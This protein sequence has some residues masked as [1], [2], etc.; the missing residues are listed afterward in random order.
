M[1]AYLREHLH[2]MRTYLREYLNKMSAY[3]RKHRK[4]FLIVIPSVLAFCVIFAFTAPVIIEKLRP[5]LSE[6]LEVLSFQTEKSLFEYTGEEITPE[7]REITF[8][9][10]KNENITKT[11]D[12]FK[13]ETYIDNIDAGKA[14]VEI[15][16]AGYQGTLVIRDVFEISP[17]QATG[18][19]NPGDFFCFIRER[20]GSAM[21]PSI[22]ETDR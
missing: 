18:L 3:L 8:R 7:I 14:G 19:R 6:E 12:E 20:E 5:V 15:S 17:V 1:R 16:L 10:R 11:S 13:I 4:M 9:N 22:W 21:L 2:K